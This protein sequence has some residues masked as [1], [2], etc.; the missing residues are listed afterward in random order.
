MKTPIAAVMFNKHALFSAILAGTLSNFSPLFAGAP[1]E[2][3]PI[4]PIKV[5]AVANLAEV[6]LGK[7]L[8]FEPR[9]SKSGLISCN[10]CHNL[11]AGGTDNLQSSVGHKWHIGPINAPTVLNSGYNIAQF[12]DGRAKDL[13]DQAGGPIQA[14]GEMAS[15]HELAVKTIASI[16]G[17]N[18][19]FVAAY[20]SKQVDI[21]RIRNAIAAFEKTLVTPD[22]KFD[23]WLAGDDKALSKTE[24]AGYDHFKNM[25]CVGCHNGEAVG[26]S[27]FQKFGLVNPYTKDTQTLGRYAVTKVET[28]K[29]VFKVP[30]LRNVEL[31]Y[32]YFHDGS[33]WTL[34]EAVDVMAW[35][36]LGRKLKKNENSELVAFLKTL[37]GK[38]PE[39][40]LPALPPSMAKTPRPDVGVPKLVNAPEDKKTL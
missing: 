13:A 29:Y 21:T 24:L 6:E 28:D 15:N 30:T 26:G 23:L 4:Q 18:K 36:Q 10:S 9:L 1:R 32:P 34:E 14:E 33:V 8:Y 22:S 19:A 25:G 16:E 11:A 20:G 38:Q 37:T 40:T 39:I 35:H 7:M 31:T 3:E 2:D 27:S 5:P 12:W 17:Y